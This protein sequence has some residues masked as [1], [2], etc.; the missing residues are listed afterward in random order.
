MT[1]PMEGFKAYRVFSDFFAGGSQ[2][3]WVTSEN[4]VVTDEELTDEYWRKEEE[5]LKGVAGCGSLGKS[6]RAEQI[7]KCE[8]IRKVQLAVAPLITPLRQGL[9]KL[10]CIIH[11]VAEA[12]LIVSG[13]G[14]A[15][16]VV[17]HPVAGA[18]EFPGAWI[19]QRIVPY[20]SSCAEAV[21]VYAWAEEAPLS[22]VFEELAEPIS[23]DL[24]PDQWGNPTTSNLLPRAGEDAR[25]WARRV[26]V[27]PGAVKKIVDRLARYED[28]ALALAVPHAATAPEPRFLVEGLFPLAAVSLVAA[29][30][31]VGK[32]TLGHELA[33]V[34][35][36]RVEP[37]KEKFFLG[38]SVRNRF[39]AA[40]ITVEEGED[41]FVLRRDRLETAWPGADVSYFNSS[42]TELEATLGLLRRHVATAGGSD[43][44]VLIIDSVRGHINGD[45][46]KTHVVTE[47]YRPLIAFARDT[48]WAVILLHH[49]TKQTPRS[50]AVFRASVSGS[51]AHIG[52]PRVSYGVI[53]RGGRMKEFGPIKYNIPE[54]FMA[55]QIGES[56]LFKENART[57]TLDPVS[58]DDNGALKASGG[59]VERVASA[60]AGLNRC[61]RIVRL[62]GKDGL[63]E[64]RLP[65]LTGMGRGFIQQVSKSLI[66]TNQVINDP[67]AGLLINDPE[68][69]AAAADT[70]QRDGEPI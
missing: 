40:Y 66:E 59:H 63:W 26:A 36:A 18:A 17:K 45:D 37:G 68:V 42:P 35:S 34:A 5:F 15:C 38:Q 12:R 48:G 64:Q 13:D 43:P 67:E 52:Y 6:W 69:R 24:E 4:L 14:L 3:E 51:E 33:H 9:P 22:E 20:G 41:M 2:A 44:G 7:R 56:R 19:F 30:S 47:F 32:S 58:S 27:P 62:S 16:T 10:G 39:Q 55:I 65:S 21:H 29:M 60:I 23:A 50:L 49:T 1:T 57:M 31:G 46:T 70:L 54:E 61:K 11:P 8:N 25:T 53:D 28:P